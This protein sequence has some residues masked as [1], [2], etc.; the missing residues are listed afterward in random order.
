MY[1]KLSTTG[2]MFFI[3]KKHT[4]V[5]IV[6]NKFINQKVVVI[7]N[8]KF[9]FHFYDLVDFVVQNIIDFFFHTTR[10]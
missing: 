9:S 6:T 7:D 8:G 2:H 1:K 10:K 5:I 3:Y 4:I